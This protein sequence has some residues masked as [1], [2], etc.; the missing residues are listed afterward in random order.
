MIGPF[1]GV[2]STSAKLCFVDR[3]QEKYTVDIWKEGNDKI[4]SEA[5][6]SKRGLAAFTFENLLPNTKY[7]Y[8]IRNANSED[9]LGENSPGQF[10]TFPNQGENADLDFVFF[11]CHFPI[12]NNSKVG[13]DPISMEMWGKLN[14]RIEE[15][16]STSNQNSIR[17][18]LGIGDQIYADE[19]WR[20]GLKAK[21]K[22]ASHEEV[23]D[24]YHGVYK[25]FWSPDS[26]K[27]VLSKCPSFMTWDDHE[28]R[29][30]WG[31][32]GDEDHE[33]Q[34]KMFKAADEAY[35]EVQLSGNPFILGP[36][37]RYYT[38]IYGKI[39]FVILD[40]RGSRSMNK[41]TLMGDDQWEWFKSW[42]QNEGQG[43]DVIFIACSVPFV[44][45]THQISELRMKWLGK[46]ILKV[47]GLADDFVDQWN[48][49]PFINE[50]VEFSEFLFRQANDKGKRF[51]LLG[52]DV[53]VGTFA[54]LRSYK[55]SDFF[56][57]VIYQCTS[58]PIS[59]KPTKFASWILEKFAPE[60]EMLP[61][62]PYKG[63]ILKIIRERN[64]GVIKVRKH[65]ERGDY[66]V[67]Y[68]CHSQKSGVKKFATQW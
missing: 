68:E 31:S 1:I 23:V 15:R 54:V 45:L 57:P 19:L 34:Q 64:F 48:S 39:G 24:S 16:L 6:S 43:C 13:F 58:S 32:C 36:G 20:G 51:V 62:I 25:K 41:K 47:M 5:V 9:I 28:I 33:F 14:K 10:Q 66:A 63:R 42:V 3:K 12:F 49:A 7:S 55:D 50:A 52:G 11:S 17:F 29:D 8:S 35:R 18:M 22:K 65:P 30:G 46:I 26:V 38:F 37:K 60:I 40:L 53:H 21:L 67:I 44:H 2:S 61:G 27:R 59:N 56:H 4:P